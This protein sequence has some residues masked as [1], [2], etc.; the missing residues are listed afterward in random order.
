MN[1]SLDDLT[2]R[3][4]LTGQLEFRTLGDG[5]AGLV[6][7]EI[8]N[9]HATATISLHGGQLLAWHPLVQPEP[10]I[11]LSGGAQFAPG[12]A[13]RGGGL[14]E[15]DPFRAGLAGPAAAEA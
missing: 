7:A 9:A 5:T 6:A 1:A 13:I 8:G 12:R 3:F 4:G 15:D 14:A 10:V 11:W 2:R